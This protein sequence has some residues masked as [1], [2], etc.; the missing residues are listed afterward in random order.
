[1]TLFK[2]GK[3]AQKYVYECVCVCVRSILEYV[4][5]MLLSS[6]HRPHTLRLRICTYIPIPIHYHVTFRTSVNSLR[7]FLTPVFDSSSQNSLISDAD[8]NNL[9]SEPLASSSTRPIFTGKADAKAVA[10]SS[11]PSFVSARAIF[12][13]LHSVLTASFVASTSVSVTPNLRV[14]DGL[15]HDQSAYDS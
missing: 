15:R 13:F 7:P 14:R 1:M 10:M 3:D 4:R 2:S 8:V 9:G 5:N 12:A 6:L 11:P